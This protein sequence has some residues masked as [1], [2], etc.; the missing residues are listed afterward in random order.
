MY[1]ERETVGGE[2]KRVNREKFQLKFIDPVCV[3]GSL[4]SCQIIESAG[5]VSA[6]TGCT[7]YI[8]VCVSVC[9]SLGRSIRKKIYCL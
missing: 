1:R 2:R 9:A 7:V 6:L 8:Y 4:T 3:T 5:G